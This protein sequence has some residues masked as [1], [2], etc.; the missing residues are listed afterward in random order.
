MPLAHSARCYTARARNLPKDQCE[1]ACIDY[2]EGLPLYTQEHQGLFQINGIQ[3]QSQHHCNLL[4]QSQD[5][6]QR[7]VDIMRLSISHEDD[8]K[9]LQ[10]LHEV[11]IGQQTRLQVTDSESCNGYWFGQPGQVQ[12]TDSELYA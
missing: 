2:P 9:K 1:F 7:G 10:S 11:L 4:N 8:L 12:I 3:T 5:M 6:A